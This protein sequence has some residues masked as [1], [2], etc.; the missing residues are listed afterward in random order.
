MARYPDFKSYIQANYEKYLKEQVFNFMQNNHDGLG[1]HSLNVLS[2]CDQ[3]V[4]NLEVKSLRCTDLPDPYIKIE[5]NLTADIVMLGLGTQKYEADRKKRWFTVSI[6]ACLADETMTIKEDETTVKEYAPGGWDKTTALDEFGVPYIYSDDLEDMAD[7]FVEMYVYGAPQINCFFPYGYVVNKLGLDVCAADLPDNTMGRIYF[8]EDRETVYTSYRIYLKG[9]EDEPIIDDPWM[10]E[11]KQ[12]NAVIK[13]G[14][15]IISRTNYYMIK[16][17]SCYMT[18]A[19]EIIHWYLHQKFFKILSLLDSGS[20]MIKCEVEPE[21]YSDSMDSLKKAR[22]FAEWQANALGMRIT[23]PRLFFD[24]VYK[25]AYEAAIEE[26]MDTPWKAEVIE[27][28]I[29]NVARIF[30]TSDFAAKQRAIQLGYDIAAGT[31]IYVNGVYQAP[32]TFTPGTLGPKQTFVIDKKG[33]EKVCSNNKNL[34]EKLDSGEF[35]Y[36]DGLVCVNDKKYIRKHIEIIDEEELLSYGV[37]IPQ[38]EKIEPIVTEVLTDYARDHVDE[39]CLIFNWESISGPSDDGGF[40]GQ[41]YLCN[42]VSA[43]NRIEHYYDPDFESNQKIE[44]LAAEVAKYKEAFKEEEKV[45][46]ELYDK[47]SFDETLI[48]HMDRKNIKVEKLAFQSDLSTTTIKKYRS[49]ESKP[50]L[51]NVMAIIIGLNLPEKYGDHI[52]GT[53][54]YVIADRTTEEK[55]YRVL[56]REHSDGTIEQWNEILGQFGLDS[57]PDKRNQK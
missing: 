5:V 32:F 17:G 57:I 28:T 6:I 40:Y 29:H 10:E 35:R 23:M 45:L 53:L 51:K 24:D 26:R 37:A 7:D 46:K 30:G 33:L 16:T 47:R 13:P 22:W 49:G 43:N 55:V 38:G 18:I 34:K 4:D 15:I 8:K 39:C 9:E 27:K 36:I 52:L 31:F 50:P 25:E 2:V 3:E 21:L 12:E 54:G 41:S 48:Y 56:M 42:D 14:T 1:F 19:H 11:S 20:S 44:D